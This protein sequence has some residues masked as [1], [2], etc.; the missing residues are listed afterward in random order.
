[1][2]AKI[3]KFLPDAVIGMTRAGPVP[4][5]VPAGAA[6]QFD[7]VNIIAGE[8][9]EPPPG[10]PMITLIAGG[11][12]TFDWTVT[13]ASEAPDGLISVDISINGAL[14]TDSHREAVPLFGSPIA[15]ITGMLAATI[16]KMANSR[17][18]TVRLLNTGTTAIVLQ[19][20]GGGPSA[21]LR[22]VRV[23]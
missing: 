10:P 2:A 14:L 18:A 1:V 15:K 11:G 13:A 22:C 16:P 20:A 12:Y 3:S 19:A 21:A 4:A 9:P 5:V 23:G 8:L 6:I 7:V 17:T